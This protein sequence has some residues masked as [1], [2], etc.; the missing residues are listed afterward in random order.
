M[1]EL[2]DIVG[3]FVSSFMLLFL[4]ELLYIVTSF[5]FK[6]IIQLAVDWFLISLYIRSC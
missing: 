1:F 4:F 2:F 6:I 3:C 5:V